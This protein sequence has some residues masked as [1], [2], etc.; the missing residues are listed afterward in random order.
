MHS[1]QQNNTVQE[2]WNVRLD[3]RDVMSHCAVAPLT[4]LY[5]GI[6]G[7][8]PLRPGYAEMEIR[9]Q[10]GDLEFVDVTAYTPQGAV[11]FRAE[12]QDGGHAISVTVPRTAVARLRK[13][14]QRISLQPGE[15]WTGVI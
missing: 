1:V 12:A 3:S 8:Q 6:L 5:Q 13:D 11:K 14:D 15:T 7:L 4:A 10:L 9:P 2:L